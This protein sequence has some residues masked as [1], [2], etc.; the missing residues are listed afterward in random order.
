MIPKKIFRNS[1]IENIID[2]FIKKIY[3]IEKNYLYIKHAST[4]S[5]LIYILKFHGHMFFFNRCKNAASPV[6]SRI[7]FHV[8]YFCNS[9]MKGHELSPLC[10]FYAQPRLVIRYLY[11]DPARPWYVVMLMT[12]TIYAVYIIGFCL[13]CRFL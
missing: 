13:H 5:W 12:G 9:F 7:N 10:V 4:S 6:F 3:C 11:V 1:F 8:W 2:T